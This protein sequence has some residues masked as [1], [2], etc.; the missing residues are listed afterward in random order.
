MSL[1]IYGDGGSMR[2]SGIYAEDYTGTFYCSDCE[3]EFELDG[4]T[5]DWG[6]MA[7]ADCP[8]CGKGLE[9][10]LPSRDERDEDADYEAY[11]DSQMD[12]D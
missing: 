6:T 7:Y 11:R 2:G 10:E 12:W 1:G 4:T 8:D 5:D 3:D 9:L